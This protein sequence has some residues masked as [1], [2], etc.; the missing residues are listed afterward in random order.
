MCRLS[1]LT[2]K[3]KSKN[4]KLDKIILLAKIIVII[5]SAY[6]VT[7]NI[8]PFFE[9]SNPYFYGVNSVIMAE[10][11][12]SITNELLQ[13]TGRTEL[14]PENWIMTDHGS[15]VPMSGTGL[16]VA[17][18]I[19]YLIGGYYGLFY[20]SPIMYIF[21][22]IA[23][24]R[25]SS[26]LFGNYVGLITLLIIS[27]SNLL[28]R[29]SIELM[30]ESIFALLF[31]VAIF[32]LIKF[33]KT[34]KQ[35]LLLFSSSLF[36]LLVWIKFSG[37]INLPLEIF[38]VY[39][40]FIFV[41]L[42]ER[43]NLRKINKNKIQNIFYPINKKIM[44]K[45]F[46]K[47]FL[48]IIIPWS[49]F[50]ISNTIYFEYYFGDPLINYGDVKEFENYDTTLSSILAF[51]YK[52]FENMKQYSKYLLPYQIPATYNNVNENFEDILGSNW[53]GLI[54]IILLLIITAISFHS[55]D[56]RTE[57][58]VLMIFIFGLASFFS[59]ITTEYRAEQGVAGRYMLPAFVLSSMV[60]GYFIQKIIKKENNGIGIVKNG[61]KIFKVI[62][63]ILIGIFFIFAFYFSNPVQ[64]IIEDGINF[65][66]PDE[67]TNRYPINK[68][69]LNKN[70]VIV[71][72]MA[73]R[74]VEYGFTSFN[75]KLNKQISTDSINLLKNIIKDEYD[76]YMFK[77]PFNNNEKNMINELGNEHGFIFKD[78]SKTF[79]KVE[80]ISDKEL[81]SDISC[82]NNEPIRKPKN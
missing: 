50:L 44:N 10:G 67:L 52:D 5:F 72:N 33:L 16:M 13:E 35:K 38:V 76:V 7:A 17:G 1:T 31:V 23:S 20:L 19:F 30:T 39:G 45:T 22:L 59:L 78:Y 26:K 24:E 28:F 11:Q 14:I 48:A 36:T 15:V 46:L 73:T 63:V 81:E 27:S 18:S 32:Y 71:T 64:I 42:R 6:G 57:V 79:C 3:K 2:N 66:N 40:F 77:I 54:T 8:L 29:N 80:I 56:K 75:P 60:F 82:I 43:K 53:I 65:K 51:E 70:D 58:F 21:L 37:L 62:L 74:A 68:E 12:F 41:T 55:K 9:G 25:T 4:K 49:F 69:G 47:I 34:K 61:I